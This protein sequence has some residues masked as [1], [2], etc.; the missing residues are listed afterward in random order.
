[1]ALAGG[2]TPDRLYDSLS[3]VLIN[4]EKVSLTLTDERWVSSG[5]SG[6]QR[7]S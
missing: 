1:M 7:I 6:L 5:R 3:N 4:W 2:T